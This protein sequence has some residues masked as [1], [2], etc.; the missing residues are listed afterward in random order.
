MH[1]RRV[2]AIASG[3]GGTGK[4]TLAVNLAG[5][6][7]APVTY[8][9]CD[10]EEPNGH[11]FLNPEIEHSAT[12]TIPVPLV[13]REKCTGCGRCVEVCRFNALACVKGTVIVFSELCH[14]CGGCMLACPEQAISEQG[15]EIGVV[16]KG[17]ANSV[18][19]IQGRLNIG[20]PMSPPL[21]RAAK[22]AAPYAGTVI[23]DA[24]PGTSCPVIAA[25]K[26]SDFVV[27][28]TEPTP[29]GLHDLTLA[30]E[31]VRQLDIPFGVA[32]NRCDNGDDR[33][34]AYCKREDIPVL[35]EIPDDRRVAEAYSR[36]ELAIEAVPGM[37]SV[38]EQLARRI[39][40]LLHHVTEMKGVK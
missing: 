32:I 6:M 40:G 37:R 39:N 10:V 16:E 27:L 13:D 26:D 8:V 33:V 2:I 20:V 15:H 4:T 14:G 7:Q 9:D 19:F 12:V 5:L 23:I 18:G 3:K 17:H 1:D 24:P 25:I 35:A 28:V 29:F 30:V 22:E 36:G 31:T 11:I 34:L 21:I 38:F